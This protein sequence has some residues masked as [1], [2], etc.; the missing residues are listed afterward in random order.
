MLLFRITSKQIPT[1]C[2]FWNSFQEPV[3]FWLPRAFCC[4]KAMKRSGRYQETEFWSSKLLAA[5]II[6]PCP[7]CQGLAAAR[8]IGLLGKSCKINKHYQLNHPPIKH[9]WN[10]QFKHLGL[11]N[12]LIGNISSWKLWMFMWSRNSVRKT[13]NIASTWGNTAINKSKWMISGALA[14]VV[15]DCPCSPQKHGAKGTPW[16]MQ[17][18]PGWWQATT[19]C[20]SLLKM[21]KPHL[22][23]SQGSA[24][25]FLLPDICP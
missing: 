14:P 17:H 18:K 7:F 22:K 8:R 6:F 5:F 13:S 25:F 21:R 16:A 9:Q 24:P 2:T 1:L 11:L 10:Y 23:T 3:S 19:S 12:T 20:A 15:F 4:N